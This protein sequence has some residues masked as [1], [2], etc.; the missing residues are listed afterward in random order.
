MRNF[1]Y[2][3]YKSF[4]WDNEILN[5]LT[6]IHEYKGKQELFL[7]QKPI[8]ME[9]LV[10]VAKIQSVESSNRIEGIVTTSTRIGQLVKEKTTPRNRDEREIAG[11]RDVLNTVHEN[12]D[13]VPVTGNIII[14]TCDLNRSSS[15]YFSLGHIWFILFYLFIFFY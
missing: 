5:Y 3:K 6:Q 7:R 1:D 15:A 12:Y 11:Y 9:K 13:Y 10:E 14:L 4:R 8:E 2:T